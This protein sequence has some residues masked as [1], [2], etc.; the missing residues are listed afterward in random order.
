VRAVHHAWQPAA[1]RRAEAAGACFAQSKMYAPN[2]MAVPRRR[3]TR[4]QGQRAARIA[5]LTLFCQIIRRWP[6]VAPVLG[7]AP[8]A[9]ASS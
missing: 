1:R 5:L 9:S 4:A 3:G 7:K 6:Q 2:M 8:Q